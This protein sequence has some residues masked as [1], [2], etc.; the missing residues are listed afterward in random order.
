M[1]VLELSNIRTS[2][3]YPRGNISH[4]YLMLVEN[5]IQFN[6]LNFSEKLDAMGTV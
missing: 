4:F 1:T 5:E 6:A 3:L 2:R